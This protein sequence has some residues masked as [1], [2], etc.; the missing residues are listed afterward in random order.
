M[1]GWSSNR[2]LHG[3][4]AILN[5]KNSPEVLPYQESVVDELQAHL[6]RQV[7]GLTAWR[8]ACTMT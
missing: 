3:L 5:E 4:Q 6:Q 7:R 8:S 1:L 2:L